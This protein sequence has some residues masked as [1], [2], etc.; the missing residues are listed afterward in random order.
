LWSFP[1]IIQDEQI[2]KFKMG[3]DVFRKEDLWNA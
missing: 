2:S 1:N 3:I